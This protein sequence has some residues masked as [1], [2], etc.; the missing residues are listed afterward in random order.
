MLPPELSEKVLG[1]D[2]LI[3]EDSSGHVEQ[4]GDERIANGIAHAHPLLSA[5]DDIAGPQYS[6]L[7][8]HDRLID[9]ERL[10]QLLHA[11]IATDQQFENPDA[12]RMG[13]RPEERRL[14]GLELPGRVGRHHRFAP[15]G[16]LP[17]AMRADLKDI[18]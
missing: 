8:G 5:D 7:L 12:H 9:A 15:R 2:E 1:P 10:L 11:A 6:E 17:A 13:K 16:T 14:E 3:V 18:Y 4:V